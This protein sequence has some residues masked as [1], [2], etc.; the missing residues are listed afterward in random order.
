MFFPLSL[1]WSCWHRKMSRPFT[2]D[3]QTYRVCLKCGVRR[4]FDLQNWKT[5]GGYYR[6]NQTMQP[7]PNKRPESFREARPRVPPLRIIKKMSVE[8]DTSSLKRASC[9]R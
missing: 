9:Q 8:P 4:A 3:G 6:E 7:D 5:Q 2:R 1:F